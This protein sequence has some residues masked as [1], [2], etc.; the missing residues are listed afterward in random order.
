M[1]LLDGSARRVGHYDPA[2]SVV[3]SIMFVRHKRLAGGLLLSLTALCLCLTSGSDPARTQPAG[4]FLRIERASSFRGSWIDLHAYVNEK[5]IGSISNG[6]TEIFAIEAGL[7]D[8][9]L[10]DCWGDGPGLSVFEYLLAQPLRYLWGQA[11]C[12]RNSRN[13]QSDKRTLLQ[14]TITHNQCLFTQ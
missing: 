8:L 14:Q 6:E 1:I 5:Y 11:P 3:T 2:L 12:G 13:W 10:K 7:N 4:A 9:Y